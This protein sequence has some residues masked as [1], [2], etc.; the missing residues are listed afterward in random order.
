M[1]LMNIYTKKLRVLMKN[2]KMVIGI[3]FLQKCN[4]FRHFTSKLL[5]FW[6]I[7]SS[8]AY[9]QAIFSFF[10]K[11]INWPF[12]RVLKIKT[13][14]KKSKKV[15]QT[16]KYQKMVHTCTRCPGC[17][18]AR[19]TENPARARQNCCTGEAR[20]KTFLPVQLPSFYLIS[21]L[22]YGPL[23]FSISLPQHLKKTFIVVLYNINLYRIKELHRKK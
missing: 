4:L 10:E 1:P 9:L 18:G 16:K 8:K 5:A 13:A 21:K 23:N 12:Q 19:A 22:S 14:P 7:C 20:Y 15:T 11:E 17:P 2:Y 6:Y 3:F